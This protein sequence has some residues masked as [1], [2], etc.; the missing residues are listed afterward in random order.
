M[1]RPYQQKAVSDIKRAFAYNRRVL[2]VFPTG[3]G[4]TFSLYLQQVGRVLR[5]APGKSHGLILDHVGNVPNFGLPEEDREWSLE[6]TGKQGGTKDPEAVKLT[7]C[8]ECFL[9]YYAKQGNICPYCGYEKE[10]EHKPVRIERGELVEYSPN[11]EKIV[12]LTVDEMRQYNWIK[13]KNLKLLRDYKAF[14]RS[15]GRKEGWGWHL[16]KMVQKMDSLKA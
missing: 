2:F 12:L 9:L 7:T 4:K 6:G 10:V 16:F 8:K 13:T 1:L 11:G 15:M 14:A 3:A 5:P